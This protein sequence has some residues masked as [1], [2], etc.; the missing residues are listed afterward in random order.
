MHKIASLTFYLTLTAV[1]S[2]GLGSAQNVDSNYDSQLSKL[3]KTL[4]EVARSVP[5]SAGPLTK[6]NQ[7]AVSRQF[8]VDN[9]PKSARDALHARKMR[10]NNKGEVQ[11]YIYVA[12]LSETMLAQLRNKGVTVELTD[13]K[14]KIVQGRVAVDRLKSVTTL[15]AVSRVQLPD[16]GVPQV[17]SIT[18]QG[19]KVLKADLVRSNFRVNGA[20]VTVGI[21]SDGIAGVFATGCASCGSAPAGPIATGD[22]PTATGTRTGAVL[23]S[24]TGGIVA[25]SFS[26]DGNLESGAEGTAMM[27]IVHDLAPGAKLMFANFD[28]GLAFNAA[29]NFLSARADVVVDDIGFFGGPGSLSRRVRG[30]WRGRHIHSRSSG[31]CAPFSSNV[32]YV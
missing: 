7:S 24:A 31:E 4:R 5:Q 20:G 32:E 11:V 28:T 8:S 26:A 22:L 23:T 16:Y 27:E 17:G 19:D 29:V 18:T 13:R 25:Q 6:S 21:I 14:H 30:F 9:L 3:S 2:V 15:P 1:L 12:D 10:I